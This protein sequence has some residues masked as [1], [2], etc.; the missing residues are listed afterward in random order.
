MFPHTGGA[1]YGMAA[2]HWSSNLKRMGAKSKVKGLYLTGGSAH[3]G[4]GVPMA[5]ISGGI[6][7]DQVI[8]DCGLTET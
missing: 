8:R 5:A 4:A 6:A 7:A 1:I 3:P 2:R